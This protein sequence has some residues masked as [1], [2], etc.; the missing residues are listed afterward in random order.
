MN[1]RSAFTLEPHL[2]AAAANYG[3]TSVEL[4]ETAT[5]AL[6]DILSRAR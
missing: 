3:S 4:F 6:K 2:S 5:N 1:K